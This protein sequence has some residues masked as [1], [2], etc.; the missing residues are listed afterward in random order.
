MA[1]N[2]VQ[3]THGLAIAMLLIILVSSVYMALSAGQVVAQR[4]LTGLYK[5]NDGGIYYVRQVDGQIWWY[6]RGAGNPPGFTNVFMGTIHGNTITGNWAD[7]PLGLTRSSG[8]LELYVNSPNS[9]SKIMDTGGF[10]GSLW[11]L[12]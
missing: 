9:F 1:R 10:A 6:G 2:V 5:C 4:D 12:R 11:T 7:V 8:I 3:I